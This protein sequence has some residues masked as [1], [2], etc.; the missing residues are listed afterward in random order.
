MSVHAHHGIEQSRRDDMESIGY[1]LVYFMKGGKLPWMGLK[2]ED[3]RERYRMIGHIKVTT[4][5]VSSLDL[6]LLI[7]GRNQHNKT[8]RW[9]QQRI[10]DI[11]QIYQDSQV[12]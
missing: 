7:I 9:N 1:M 5:S 12:H 3:I 4:K 2:T 11:S 8:M 10:R 6:M